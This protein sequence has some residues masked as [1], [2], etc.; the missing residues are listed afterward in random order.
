VHVVTWGKNSPNVVNCPGRGEKKLYR[1]KNKTP[2]GPCAHLGREDGVVYG[3]HASAR[4]DL[5]RARIVGPKT[6]C[7]L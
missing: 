5:L 3:P 4:D 1:L 6:L 7:G 2:G